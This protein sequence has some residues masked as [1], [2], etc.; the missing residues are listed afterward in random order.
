MKKIARAEELAA[1]S[2]TGREVDTWMQLPFFNRK[3]VTAQRLSHHQ[4]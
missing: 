1:L 2:L 4:A 3:Q